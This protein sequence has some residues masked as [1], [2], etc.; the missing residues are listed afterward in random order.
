MIAS[1]PG[2]GSS[3]LEIEPTASVP[4]ARGVGKGGK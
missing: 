3:A 4:A 1:D 2:G